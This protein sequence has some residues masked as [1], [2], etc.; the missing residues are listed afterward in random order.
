MIESDILFICSTNYTILNS[1]NTVTHNL[2]GCRDKSDIVIFLRNKDMIP[3]INKVSGLCIFNNVY[4]YSFINYETSLEKIK[5]ILLP[6]LFLKK[7]SVDDFKILD[8]KNNKYYKVIITQSL[9]Y[10]MLFKR[11]YSDSDVYMLEEGLSSYTTR[12]ISRKRRNAIYNILNKILFRG[13]ADE[14]KGQLLYEEEIFTGDKSAVP[15]YKLP[16][17]DEDEMKVLK[18]IFGDQNN[19]IYQNKEVVYLGTPLFGLRG[20]LKNPK[21]CKNNFE[22]DC[23]DILHCAL[24]SFYKKNIIYRKHPLEKEY[25]IDITENI[26]LDMENNMWELEAGDFVNEHSILISFFSTA[27]FTPKLLYG[28]EPYLLFLYKLTREPMFQA[29]QVVDGLRRCYIRPEKI[30]VP[31]T[32]VELL[33]LI[34]G[35]EGGEAVEQNKG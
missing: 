25:D 15:I 13:L 33:A 23:E 5:L 14:I 3:Y 7:Y 6:K 12:T 4:V 35:L 18:L 10:S 17:I 32:R 28:K 2:I 20:L 22:K 27:A 29:D 26:C 30:M 31:E 19:V 24:R 21:K 8:F 9:F 34:G 11:I 16:K 1:V